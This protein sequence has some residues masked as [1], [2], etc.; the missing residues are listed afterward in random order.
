MKPPIV[1]TLPSDVLSKLGPLPECW[2][3]SLRTAIRRWDEL[4]SVLDLP[5]EWAEEVAGAAQSFALFTTREFVS[6]MRPGD[7]QDPLLLQVLPQAQEREIAGHLSVDPVGDRAAQRA[8]GLLRKYANRALMV[9]TGACAVHCRYCFR[10][11]FPYEEVPHDTSAWEPALQSLSRE[12]DVDEV[13]LSGGDPLMLVDTRLEQLTRRL[14]DI[15]HLRRLRIHTR[16]PVVLPQRVT[17]SLLEA[18]TG[19]RLDCWV[20]IHCNHAQEL[21]GSV[22]AAIERLH[23]ARVPVLNQTVLLRGIND[24][25]ATLVELSRSL[26]DLRVLPYYLHLLDPVIGAQHFDV[27]EEEGR[28]FV[29]TMRCELSGF[30]VPRLVRELPGQPHKTVIA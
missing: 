15:P 2:Q 5:A 16:L 10:R 3:E 13:I 30:G 26:L 19:T 14:A 21:D 23:A 29:E 11:H 17:D 6:R 8:P 12:P 25:A 20:V 27:T 18:L 7:P 28:A 4:A 22:A 1:S 9:A 24:S